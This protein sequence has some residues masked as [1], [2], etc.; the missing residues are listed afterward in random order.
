MRVNPYVTASCKK[1]RRRQGI[2]ND[3]TCLDD[4]TVQITKLIRAD[5]LSLYARQHN[6]IRP[7][8]IPRLVS[9][10]VVA[11]MRWVFLTGGTRQLPPLLM[12]AAM[13]VVMSYWTFATGVLNVARC[14]MQISA[15]RFLA[16]TLLFCKLHAYRLLVFVMYSL[17]KIQNNWVTAGTHLLGSRTLLRNCS[18]AIPM[19]SHVYLAGASASQPIGRV[20]ASYFGRSDCVVA[21]RAVLSLALL[22]ATPPHH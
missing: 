7:L 3:E 19:S 10:L 2:A 8:A 4:T 6:S 15:L 1:Q 18:H 21:S 11:M 22:A 20:C 5:G 17:C 14:I 9:H 16:G 13:L 12:L